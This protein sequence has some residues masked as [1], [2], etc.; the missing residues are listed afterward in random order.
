MYKYNNN[1]CNSPLIWIILL[2]AILIS[3]FV[4]MIYSYNKSDVDLL[5]IFID[6]KSNKEV[7]NNDDMNVKETNYNDNYNN[8]KNLNNNDEN[9]D[10]VIPSQYR[11]N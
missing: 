6:T 10:N 9:T 11:Y 5:K 8:K 1:I 4:A 3:L 2:S 7:F